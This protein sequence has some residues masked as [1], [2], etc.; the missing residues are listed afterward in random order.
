[1]ASKKKPS[2]SEDVPLDELIT[3]T[4]A[5]EI[6]FAGSPRF[7]ASYIDRACYAAEHEN[8]LFTICGDKGDLTPRRAMRAKCLECSGTA[9]EVKK[10]AVVD[11]PLWPYRL[12]VG[13]C[14]NLEGVRDKT[15]RSLGQINAAEQNLEKARAGT[16]H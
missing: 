15:P 5:V 4:K 3:I 9:Y 8:L 2:K 6:V 13:V 1:M 14:T 12:G 16:R 7:Q 11:C 10:C